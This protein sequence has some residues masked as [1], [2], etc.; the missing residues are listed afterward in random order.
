MYQS[1]GG[2]SIAAGAFGGAGLRQAAVVLR[3]AKETSVIGRVKDLQNLNDNERTLLDRLPDRGSPKANWKQNS[4]VLRQ[5]MNR[6]VPIRDASPGD[7]SG[8][9]LNAERNLLKDR[10]WS[11][12]S[13]TNYWNPPK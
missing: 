11:F 4:S 9:F 8:K 5:E 6:G 12:D 2:A 1:H 10:G 3:T 13:K 7:M